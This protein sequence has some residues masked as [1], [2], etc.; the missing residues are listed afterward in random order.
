MLFGESQ[1]RAL[2]TAVP[3][4]ADELVDQFHERSINASKIGL[5]GGLQLNLEAAAGKHSKKFSW[6]VADLHRTWAGALEDYLA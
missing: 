3:E 4:K 2:L 6:D 1:S 5:V